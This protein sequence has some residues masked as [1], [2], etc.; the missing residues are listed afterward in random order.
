MRF[1]SNYL[2]SESEKVQISYRLKS[3]Y[4][5]DHIFVLFEQWAEEIVLERDEP[6]PGFA[7]GLACLSPN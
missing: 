2:R 1:F 4:Y 7:F 5:V 3:S 6:W